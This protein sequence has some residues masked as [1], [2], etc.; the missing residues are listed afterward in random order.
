MVVCSV[1][2]EAYSVDEEGPHEVGE[3]E[4]LAH[5]PLGELPQRAGTAGPAALGGEDAVLTGDR[6]QHQ[7][8]RVDRR[9]RQVELRGLLD[10]QLR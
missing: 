2:R 6:R 1:T 3:H 5:A 8:R 10:P 9:E 7:H 4:P